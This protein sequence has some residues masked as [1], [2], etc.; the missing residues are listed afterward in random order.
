VVCNIIVRKPYSS[1][2]WL[3][4]RPRTTSFFGLLFL[5]SWR[6]LFT[7]LSLPFFFWGCSCGC[8][9]GG[10]WAKTWCSYLVGFRYAQ[11]EIISYISMRIH[12]RSYLIII[13]GHAV[14]FS[15]NPTTTS[16][17]QASISANQSP[18]IIDWIVFREKKKRRN[19]K[20]RTNPSSKHN[21]ATTP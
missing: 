14:Y 11:A 2:H 9:Y 8:S 4:W 12:V 7:S 21:S 13:I 1:H 3:V 15:E 5:S 18:W 17:H 19:Q 10:W 20:S 16:H 6:V